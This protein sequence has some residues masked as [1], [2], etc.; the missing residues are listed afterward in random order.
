MMS[1]EKLVM[2]RCS[3]PTSKSV[4]VQ[5]A[6]FKAPE[7]MVCGFVGGGASAPPPPLQSDVGYV[8]T[9]HTVAQRVVGHPPTWGVFLDTLSLLQGAHPVARKTGGH[10]EYESRRWV[11]ACVWA[12][13]HVESLACLPPKASQRW[14]VIRTI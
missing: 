3:L 2:V 12:R 5:Y 11:L 13:W 1:G 4:A 8:L 7:C 14:A 6:I 9:H 10:V